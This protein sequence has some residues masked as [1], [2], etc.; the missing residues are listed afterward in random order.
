MC[1]FI[2]KGGNILLYQWY[3]STSSVS[4]ERY[5]KGGVEG[6]GIK[7]LNSHIFSRS[8]IKMFEHSSIRGY[9]IKYDKTNR[10]Y[11]ILFVVFI[12]DE[13]R[14]LYGRGI[15]TTI[16]PNGYLHLA[17]QL[18]YMVHIQCLDILCHEVYYRALDY[19]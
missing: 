10:F 19:F 14:I 6:F 7:A 2:Q 18:L 11:R 8:S 17:L 16:V 12:C 5:S 15:P 9:K 13:G 4:V 3:Q 1:I